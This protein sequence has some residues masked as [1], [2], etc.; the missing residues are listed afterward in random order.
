MERLPISNNAVY[1]YYY[2]LLLRYARR[3][4]GEEEAAAALANEVLQE[5]FE[6]G[7][8]VECTGLRRELFIAINFR[9][10]YWVQS[11]VFDKEMVKVPFIDNNQTD[12]K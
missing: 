2:P 4:V 3:R 1:C 5:K 9:C 7:G 10:H 12:H 6:E 8:L 11:R